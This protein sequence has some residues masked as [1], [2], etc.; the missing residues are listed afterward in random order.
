MMKHA[1]SHKDAAVPASSAVAEVSLKSVYDG[2]E[3]A[4]IERSLLRRPGVAA[5]HLDRTRGV[6]L[7]QESS[8]PAHEAAAKRT[9]TSYAEMGN[10][11]E[12]HRAGI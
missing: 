8:G 7:G 6:A 4:D 11:R 5:V 9:T 10:S 12:G 1:G 3:Y 2:S